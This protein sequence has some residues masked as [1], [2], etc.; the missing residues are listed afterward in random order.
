MV[1]QMLQL[2]PSKYGCVVQQLGVFFI[3]LRIPQ[4]GC[5]TVFL[6]ALSTLGGSTSESSRSP[7]VFSF[8]FWVE[9]SGS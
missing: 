4:M 7:E 9:W 1:A 3:F 5:L 6:L 8:L 2:D